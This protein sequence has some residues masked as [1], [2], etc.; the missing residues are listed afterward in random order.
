MGRANRRRKKINTAVAVAMVVAVEL[1]TK[2]G[3]QGFL[4][5]LL[6]VVGFGQEKKEGGKDRVRQS[7]HS[8]SLSP[9]SFGPSP[10]NRGGRADICT[11]LPL[12]LIFR[13]KRS[14]EE[15]KK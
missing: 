8:D 14:G 9:S 13:E 10:A 1:E 2:S 7:R 12:P 3:R 6:G 5:S 15:G 11:P 4:P